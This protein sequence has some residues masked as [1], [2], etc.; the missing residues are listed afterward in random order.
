MIAVRMLV[1]LVKGVL[2]GGLLGGGLWYLETG[3]NLES[4]EA[5]FAWLRWPLYGVIGLLTGVVAG[6][7]PWAKGAWVTSIVKAI[8][9]F[10]LGVGLFFLV[11]SF[12]SMDL[13]GRALTTW[14]FGF[15]A[16][17][18]ALYGI[19]VEV[20]DGGKDD[21]KKKALKAKPDTPALPESDA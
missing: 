10:G 6:R 9:G 16:A 18:A 1:G 11:S 15:G 14:Y 12:L 8:V 3:G 2:V 19:W 7:P 5:T 21:D 13:W 20:D 17:V 4:T